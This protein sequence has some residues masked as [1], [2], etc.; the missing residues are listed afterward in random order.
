MSLQP[1]ARTALSL[2]CGLI[3]TACGGNSTSSENDALLGG[4]ACPDVYDPVCAL[5][6][7]DN[8]HHRYQTFGN[9][10][11]AQVR[12]AKVAFESRCGALENK[13]SNASQ[14]VI[15][16]DSIGQLPEASTGFT[17]LDSEITDDVAKLIIEHGGGCGEHRFDLHV[18][19]PF[20]ESWPLQIHGRLTHETDDTCLAAITTAVNIDLLPLKN[21]YRMS[22]DDG[23]GEIMIPQVGLYQF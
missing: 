3:L 7:D 18:A 4:L 6:K 13:T 21:L 17:I 2:I 23:P 20:M 12:G 22:Y 19:P 16:H 14:A 11:Q 9:G 8:G 15:V 5:T 1:L 10:C